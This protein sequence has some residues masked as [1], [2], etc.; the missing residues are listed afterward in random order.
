[1]KSEEF[2]AGFAAQRLGKDSRSWKRSPAAGEGFQELET[3]SSDWGRIP[4]AGN[5]LQQLGKN[6][7]GWKRSPAAGEGFPALRNVPQQLG[8]K[9]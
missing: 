2:R 5:A 4:G 6:S 8:R 3:F 7:R 1:M 9:S